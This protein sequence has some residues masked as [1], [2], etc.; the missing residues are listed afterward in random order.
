MLRTERVHH[1]DRVVD[2]AV[3]AIRFL[4]RQPFIP[5]DQRTDKVEQELPVLVGI[6]ERKRIHGVGLPILRDLV[7]GAAE[8]TREVAVTAADVQNQRDRVVLLDVSNLVVRVETLAAFGS[9]EFQNAEGAAHMPV[10]MKQPLIVGFVQ[11]EVLVLEVLV[12][13]VSPV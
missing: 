1:V 8:L 4:A 3:L 10:E 11:A 12:D 7:V 5:S 6:F 13:R 9:S 2:G